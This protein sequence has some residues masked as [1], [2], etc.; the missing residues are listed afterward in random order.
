[1]LQWLQKNPV[2]ILRVAWYLGHLDILG[3]EQIDQLAKETTLLPLLLEPTIT[4]N[5]YHACKCLKRDWTILWRNSSLQQGSWATANQI[6][7]S[8]HSTP[9]FLVLADR[10]EL[11]GQLLQCRTG[12]SYSEKYYQRFVSSAD[13]VC[14]C[15]K[16]IQTWEHV[17]QSYLTYEKHHTALCKVL[18][19]LCLS[20]LLG[21][22]DSIKAITSFLENFRAFTKNG[23]PPLLLS[24]SHMI[25]RPLTDF[26]ET[27]PQ[28]QTP[29]TISFYW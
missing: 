4:H 15:S 27:E 19:M 8:L 11:F 16:P 2:N 5:I 7:L 17:I 9:H 24:I 12:H 25:D 20:D 14:L 26:I 10:K 21:T 23:Q 3:N 6:L 28:T 13:L 29:R 22:K 18:Q 1:M